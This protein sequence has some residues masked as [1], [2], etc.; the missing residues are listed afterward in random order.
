MQVVEQEANILRT[1]TQN[2]EQENDKL[3]AEI[4]KLQ[5]QSARNSIKGINSLVNNKENDAQKIN[6]EELQKECEN[7]RAKLKLI[8]SGPVAL[9]QRTPKIYS[10]TKTKLQLKVV[11]CMT[12]W[13]MK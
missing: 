12:Q 5:L 2:L 7:L 10:D 3:L 6:L 11:K 9:P 4:K 8:E 13:V 1:K